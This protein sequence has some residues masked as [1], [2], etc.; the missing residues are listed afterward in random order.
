MC[1]YLGSRKVGDE[2]LYI[3]VTAGTEAEGVRKSGCT[4]V[5]KYLSEGALLEAVAE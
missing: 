5:E 2:R 1:W 3:V 4:T